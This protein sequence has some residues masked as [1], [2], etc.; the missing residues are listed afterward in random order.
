RNHR[1]PRRVR[2]FRARRWLRTQRDWLRGALR[3]LPF[4]PR[5]VRI[6]RQPGLRRRP[7]APL[8]VA[9]LPRLLPPRRVRFHRR[10]EFPRVRLLRTRRRQRAHRPRRGRKF[11][12]ALLRQA[13]TRGRLP[14]LHLVRL[15]CAKAQILNQT[16]LATRAV[17]LH[18]AKDSLRGPKG[19]SLPQRRYFRPRRREQLPIR[20]QRRRVA[21]G[22]ARRR[23]GGEH[24]RR[25]VRW[26][27]RERSGYWKSEMSR[28]RNRVA[29]REFPPRPLVAEARL[30]ACHDTWRGIRQGE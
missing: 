25:Q 19:K 16:L 14:V 6:R 4:P 26:R 24:C 18:A 27:E 8:P 7:G 1:E 5:R 9:L 28:L 12:H 23:N 2:R 10:R 21:S 22:E 29:A 3:L 13:R 11:P 30:R 20:S 17:K 15:R